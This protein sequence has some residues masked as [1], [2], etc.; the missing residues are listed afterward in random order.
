MGGSI[1]VPIDSSR[2]V[3]LAIK[4]YKETD[5]HFD[6]AIPAKEYL[7]ENWEKLVE[8]GANTCAYNRLV[9]F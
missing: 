4:M 3:K 5:E 7:G 6:K 1:R 2:E 8:K 9:D